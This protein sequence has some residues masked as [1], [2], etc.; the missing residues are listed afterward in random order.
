MRLSPFDPSLGS[1]PVHDEAPEESLLRRARVLV[2]DDHP[3][4]REGLIQL[5][6]IA[7]SG[8]PVGTIST[9]S[10]LELGS[11]E[12]LL[13]L[14]SERQKVPRAPVPEDGTM[15][16]ETIAAIK[17]YQAKFCKTEVGGKIWISAMKRF[18]K[19]MTCGVPSI[20]IC[21]ALAAPYRSRI[22]AT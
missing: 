20:R 15:G 7:V 16:P 6:R 13:N 10:V 8:S 22:R 4:F 2:I 5:L 21:S 1:P 9:A 17:E 11:V 3:I 18:G 12:S 14:T 19:L